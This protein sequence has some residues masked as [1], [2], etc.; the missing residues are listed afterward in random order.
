VVSNDDLLRIHVNLL[1][2]A[3]HF[4]HLHSHGLRLL[5][6]LLLLL[7]LLLLL[8][9]LLSR[10]AIRRLF[11]F[12]EILR[13]TGRRRERGRGWGQVGGRAGGMPRTPA[14]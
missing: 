13:R 5:L 9:L 4:G 11:V 3:A 10:A 12:N 2:P 8:W 7:R 6:L 1:L 14:I